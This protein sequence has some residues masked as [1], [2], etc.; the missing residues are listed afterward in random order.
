MT[1]SRRVRGRRDRGTFIRSP[2]DLYGEPARPTTEGRTPLRRRLTAQRRQITTDNTNLSEGQAA[3]PHPDLTSLDRLVGTWA[4]S[5]EARGT[6]V[7]ECTEG[8]FFLLQHV[9]LGGNKGLEVIGHEHKYGEGPARTSGPATTVSLKA[10][11][12]TTPTRSRTTH[13]LS[14]WASGTPRRTTKARSA[15]MATRSPVPGTIRAAV[16]TRLCRPGPPA[17]EAKPSF[18]RATPIGA[19][20][21]DSVVLSLFDAQ[22]APVVP[23]KNRC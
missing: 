5:G 3:Q 2:T 6:V 20:P 15:R 8:G 1:L 13:S 4:V 19:N 12:W 18:H 14:G 11:R 21:P 23:P 7:Y 9:D 22:S 16:A 17:P 10:R